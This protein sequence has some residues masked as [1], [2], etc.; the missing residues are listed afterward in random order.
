MSEVM[1]DLETMGTGGNSAIV[2]IGA[3]FFDNDEIRGNWYRNV[4]LQSCIDAG[5]KVTGDT[6]MWWLKQSLEARDALQDSPI[7][8]KG[9]LGELKGAFENHGVVYVWGNGASFDNILLA[10]AYRAVGMEPPWEFWNDRCYRTLKNEYPNI[11]L[12]R[13]GVHHNALAD[14]ITQTNHLLAIRKYQAEIRAK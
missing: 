2:S 14:A 3:C 9:A 4:D 12:V 7:P 6:V 8:L 10:D 5:M 11:P 13:E 1:L